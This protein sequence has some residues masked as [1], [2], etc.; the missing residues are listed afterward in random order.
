MARSLWKAL[1]VKLK[2][3]NSTHQNKIKELIAGKMMM[4]VGFNFFLSNTTLN[5]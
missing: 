3:I 4:K 2:E 5:I 1:P